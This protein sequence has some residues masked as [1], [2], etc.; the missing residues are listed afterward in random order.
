MPSQLGTMLLIANPAAQNGRGAD[1]A[2]EAAHLLRTAVGEQALD[3]V[4]TERPGHAVAL[5][6]AADGYDT[7]LALGGDG[8]IHEVAGGLMERTVGVRPALGIVP[9]GSGNDYVRTLGM[10]CK[11]EHACAQLLNAA[12][13]PADLGRVNGHWFV[14]T[15]SFGLDAAIALDTV[16][17][18]KRT[19]RTGTIL[20][21]EAGIDQLLHHLDARRYTA[22]FDGGAPVAGASITFAVQIGPSYGGGFKICPDAR[23]DDGLFDV[24]IAHPPIGVAGAALIFALA[25]SGRHTGFKQMEFR[26]VSTLHVEFDEVPP[27]QM[28]GE[29]IEATT[30]DVSIEPRALNVLLPA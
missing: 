11:V 30:F 14:E 25:K 26:R 19:G 4:L 12:P 8:I 1:A 28:D 20:Y 29:L 22:S 9:V 18:R 3:V 10:S 15:L 24:C 5:A 17:R 23:F 2:T 27:A 21:A 7:V 16:E 6:A 13:H